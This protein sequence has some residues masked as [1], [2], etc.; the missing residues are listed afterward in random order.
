MNP[1]GLNE[2]DAEVLLLRF[3]AGADYREIGNILNRS[4]SAAAGRCL[5]FIRWQY[6]ERRKVIDF[7]NNKISQLEQ[8]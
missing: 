6:G 1:K 3:R 8:E 2:K 5:G 7:L 4:P